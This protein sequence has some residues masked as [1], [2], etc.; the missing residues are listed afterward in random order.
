MS[1]WWILWFVFSVAD[2]H[3]MHMPVDEQ[4]DTQEACEAKLDT[5]FATIL[6]QWPDDPALKTY[7]EEYHPVQTKEL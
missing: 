7:C 6:S 5:W 1:G 4:F 2:G 3:T